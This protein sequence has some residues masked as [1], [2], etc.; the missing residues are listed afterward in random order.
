MRIVTTSSTPHGDHH[1]CHVLAC[2]SHRTESHL[3]CANLSSTRGSEQVHASI[4]PF[5]A[6]GHGGR[7]VAEL[8]AVISAQRMQGFQG[9]ITMSSR[10]VTIAET[11]VQV[12]PVQGRAHLDQ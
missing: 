10:L 8:H 12:R 11:V 9:S 1:G 6:R 4:D 5:V 3:L 7:Y 2:R